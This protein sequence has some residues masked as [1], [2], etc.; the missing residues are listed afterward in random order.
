MT[1]QGEKVSSERK[2]CLRATKVSLGRRKCFKDKERVHRAPKLSPESQK[3]L[4]DGISLQRGK[5]GMA[6]EAQYC[7][8]IA[9]K[10]SL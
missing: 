7:I 10:V 1:P 8:S 9:S 4:Q 5:S 3:V 2:K 6:R